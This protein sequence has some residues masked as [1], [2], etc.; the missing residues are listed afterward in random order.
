[1]RYEEIEIRSVAGH[2]ETTHHF[3]PGLTVIVGRNGSGKSMFLRCCKVLLDGAWSCFPGVKADNISQ[4]VGGGDS[5]IRGI[6]SHRDDRMEI[7]RSLRG[8]VKSQI[9][10]N[11]GAIETG[12]SRI[13]AVV[14]EVLGI[15]FAAV[16]DCCF[17][18]QRELFR[19]LEGAAATRTAALQQL[20][21]G[22]RAAAVHAALSIES[23]KFSRLGDSV[24]DLD[25]AVRRLAEADAKITAAEAEL[26]ALP[27]VD[28]M[29]VN[30]AATTRDFCVA[31]FEAVRRFRRA[32]AAV[33][34]AN[35][36]LLLWRDRS[37]EA[38]RK[39]EEASQRF[40]I[41][42][43]DLALVI[44]VTKDLAAWSAAAARR[45][46]AAMRLVVLRDERVGVAGA[47]WSVDSTR[48]A[49]DAAV[50]AKHAL[51]ASRDAMS[52]FVAAFNDDAGE[53]PTCGTPTRVFVD[54]LVD[55]RNRLSALDDEVAKADAAV[56]LA[57]VAFS[58]ATRAAGRLLAIDAG[59]AAAEV[60]VAI[61]L[62][63]KPEIATEFDVTAVASRI[64]DEAKTRFEAMRVVA[65]EMRSTYLLKQGAV[66]ETDRE[67]RAA[68]AGLASLGRPCKGSWSRSRRIVDATAP[69][70]A[71]RAEISGRL[72]ELREARSHLAATVVELERRAAEDSK[73]LL[74]RD[75]VDRSKALT[76]RDGLPKNVAACF[77]RDALSE[78]NSLLREFDSR[79]VVDSGDDLE[80]VASYADGRTQPA[81]RLSPGEKGVLSLA[82]WVT[83]NS[84][85]A[86][87]LGVFALDEPTDGLDDRNVDCVSLA[88]G[89]LREFSRDRGLQSMIVTHDRRLSVLGDAELDF[90]DP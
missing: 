5:F 59:I 65:D 14:N 83:I 7:T 42:A 37:C 77:L 13:S 79:F 80:F 89:R 41:A 46:A 10:V 40:K 29:V 57:N 17:V 68:A 86:G 26:A 24:D 61:E 73:L 85:F 52:K 32:S 25:A 60:D 9:R 76:H 11:G 12:E 71:A 20:L 44:R 39:F 23:A 33:R 47:T 87:E 28:V 34:D 43:D 51:V 53:C 27:V 50:S 19:F 64:V 22:D 2:V 88:I 16:A 49:L 74:W 18:M 75:V 3:D 1:M 38:D 8:R 69:T 70:I 67:L 4:L 6:V 48:S 78:V 36:E 54:R 31:R 58:D 55:A 82:F 72:A 66:V 90:G 35:R 84:M 62:P 45:D 15:D 30:A 21:G 63:P 56:A 81:T